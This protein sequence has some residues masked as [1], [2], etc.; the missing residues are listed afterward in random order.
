MDDE[1]D[2]LADWFDPDEL[3]GL[4]AAELLRILVRQGRHTHALL[5]ERLAPALE[6]IAAALERGG[7][8]VAPE[9]SR[10]GSVP[11]AELR[12]RLDASRS[13][14][15]PDAVIALRDE[16]A[17]QLDVEALGILDRE[18]VGWLIKL[19]QRRMRAGTVRTDVVLL[20]ARVADRFGTTV[21]GASLR[22][23]LPTLRRSAGLCPVCGEPYAG[24]EDRCPRCQ[25]RA[26]AEAEPGAPDDEGDT[27]PAAESAS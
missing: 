8:L 24:L 26:V 10:P 21:E 27:P 3:T 19:I 6:R 17:R 9:G 12:A 7:A 20:A 15:D 1:P 22:A 18:V 25:A 13:A 23:S 14:N 16:L 4:D 11:V 2:D 5:A